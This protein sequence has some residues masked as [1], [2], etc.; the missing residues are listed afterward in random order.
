MNRELARKVA[1]SV[2][3][4]GY[5][6]YPYRPSAVKNRQR[7]CF[8]ILYPPAFAEVISGTERS[9]M[10]SECLLQG[11][12]DARIH[13]ELRFLHL[14][15]TQI[16]HRIDDGLEAVPSLPIDGHLVE[17]R[18][19]AIARSVIF[20]FPLH[21]TRRQHQFNFPA[22]NKEEPLCDSSGK[23]LGKTSYT[24]RGLQGVVL[25]VADEIRDGVWKITIDVDNQTP[26]AGRVDDRHTALPCSLLSTQTIL[27]AAAPQ[28]VS[29]LDP[30]SDLRQESTACCNIG[31]FPV[32]LGS[33]GD[34][35]MMLCSPILLYDYPQI[36][37][38]S[39]G[40]FY[41]STEMDEMLTLR[42]MTLTEEEKLQMR[43]AGD[44]TRNL[45]ERTEATA[46]EQLIR[47]HG[48][49]RQLRSIGERP[50]EKSQ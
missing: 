50:S 15:L 5:M 32:L 42:V 45:L 16:F 2:L 35:E 39:S 36:A 17:S 11:R 1:D 19:D 18:D 25:V 27:D 31:N 40:D 43:L 49:I 22:N 37:P 13:I 46:R 20:E 4:E 30:P 7:W 38:E 41:D 28:F 3:Y 8:G 47:T 34:R 10:H 26:L 29:L 12:A 48:T 21:A 6:L 14:T 24:Q 23:V 44:H 33:E 9:R